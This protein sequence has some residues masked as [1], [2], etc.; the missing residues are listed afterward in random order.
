MPSVEHFPGA[1]SGHSRGSCRIEFVKAVF[2]L[3]RNGRLPNS[4]SYLITSQHQ[5]RVKV[6][7]AYP[8]IPKDQKS[9][10]AEYPLFVK[11][12]GAIYAILPA[13]PVSSLRSEK[14]TAMLKS[15]IWAWPLSSNRMLSGLRS[16]RHHSSAKRLID[17]K[18]RAY[19]CTILFRCR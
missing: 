9:T 1:S 19:L 14:C 5:L 3:P 16:L 6:D 13:T 12:S 10:G 4:S 2:V 11:T 7:R 17:I 15:V 8:N 18:V